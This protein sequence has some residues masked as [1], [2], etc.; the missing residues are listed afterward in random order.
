MATTS[1]F[2]TRDKTER[3]FGKYLFT[4]RY[5]MACSLQESSLAT[6]HAIW[7]GA[8]AIEVHDDMT[9][10]HAADG[11]KYV[12]A[13]M[14]LTQRMVKELLPVLQH[15]AETG[16]LPE[17]PDNIAAVDSLVRVTGSE[18]PSLDGG[19][20]VLRYIE[21]GRILTPYFVQGYRADGTTWSTWCKEVQKIDQS[22]LGPGR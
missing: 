2:F 18:Y 11:K 10:V 9:L 3:G 16:R 15:F 22:E 5:K 4:D 17:T 19:V 21:E 13:R 8:E 14:H 20:G 12:L 6:E 7:L 1:Q